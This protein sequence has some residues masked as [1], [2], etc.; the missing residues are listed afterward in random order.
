MKKY[1][2]LFGRKRMRNTV[3]AIISLVIFFAFIKFFL[4]VGGIVALC[5]SG[6]FLYQAVCDKDNRQTL[7]KK[8]LLPAVVAMVLCFGFTGAL[9][10]GQQTSHHE[11]AGS[12]AKTTHKHADSSS[13]DDSSDDNEDKDDFDS[14]S[15][16]DSSEDTGSTEDT[17]SER[18]SSTDISTTTENGNA[19]L[20][21]N[22]DMTTDQVGTI[23]G[24]SR[25]MVYHTPG[26]HGYRMNSGNA[27]YFNSEAEAQAAGYRKALR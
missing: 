9:S 5:A 13:T 16:E 6:Y 21:N 18:T 26:Q 24:N 11:A 17:A 25:T 27:V 14:E 2:Y 7:L 20:H 4:V 22:G 3:I 15:S 1:F 23:V 19:N 10:G 8:R 12:S